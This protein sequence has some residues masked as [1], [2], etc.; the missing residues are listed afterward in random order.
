MR[1]IEFRGKRI[2]TSE[3]VYGYYVK[4]GFTG[5]EKHYIVPGYASALYAIEVDPATVGQYTGLKDKAGTKIYEGDVCKV[6][7][8]YFKI[9]NEKSVAVFHN[10][11]FQFQ[12]GCERFFSKPH[13]AW[14]EVEII[15][16]AHDNPDLLNGEATT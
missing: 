15:G 2:D 13:D 12:Y 5:K 1:E 16:N 4:Y 7:L 6:S 11:A 8:S 10:G 14:D 3:W 9:K